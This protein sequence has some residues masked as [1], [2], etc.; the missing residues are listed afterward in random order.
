ME[1]VN[2]NQLMRE[3]VTSSTAWQFNPPAAPHMGGSWERLIQSVKRNLMEVLHA[4]RPT[5]EELRNA[6][7][8]IEGVLNTRPLTHVPIDD[9]AAPALTPNHFLLGS[10]DGSKPLSLVDADTAALRR[11]HPTSQWLANLFWKRWVRDYLPD[12]TR[13][14]KWYE[15]AKPL[16]VGD[17]V[18]IVDPEHPRSCWPKG[19]VIGVTSSGRQTRKA[20]VQTLHGIYERPTVKLAVLDVRREME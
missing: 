16:Q 12:I 11:G 7:T 8:E 1:A 5:D 10:S 9:E 19:R 20:T 14:T 4:R 17:V 18:V 15:Q 2:Q 3:F 13:R 6:L